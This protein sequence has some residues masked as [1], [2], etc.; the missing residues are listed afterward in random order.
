MN[1]IIFFID[2]IDENL[3]TS[4]FGGKN[5]AAMNFTFPSENGV[6]LRNIHRNSNKKRPSAEVID[7]ISRSVFFISLKFVSFNFLFDN[8]HYYKS[9]SNNDKCKYSP[10]LDT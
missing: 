10:Y 7:W 1:I 6:L 5:E 4:P 8:T 2:L 3:L 9:R